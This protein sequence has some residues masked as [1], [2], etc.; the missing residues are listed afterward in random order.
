MFIITIDILMMHEDVIAA[1]SM[2]KG[3]VFHDYLEGSSRNWSFFYPEKLKLN[4][5]DEVQDVKLLQN[6]STFFSFI[7][8]KKTDMHPRC[9]V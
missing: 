7:W 9:M 5:G 8:V 1:A 2:A 6:L 3:D 4:L